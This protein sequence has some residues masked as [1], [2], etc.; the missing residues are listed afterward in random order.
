MKRFT[1]ITV[2]IMMVALAIELGIGI[3]AGNYYRIYHV[4]K[5]GF[6]AIRVVSRVGGQIWVAPWVAL[7][8]HIDVFAMAGSLVALLVFGALNKF[9]KFLVEG[10]ADEQS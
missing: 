7:F 2:A 8:H 6:V 9:S 3:F 1:K 10:K 4:I 5:P